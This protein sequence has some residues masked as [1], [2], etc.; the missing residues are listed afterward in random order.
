M[1]AFSDRSLAPRRGTK[2]RDS[3]QLLR[4]IF[5]GFAGVDTSAVSAYYLT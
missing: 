2:R 4:N 5:F 3:A 1:C